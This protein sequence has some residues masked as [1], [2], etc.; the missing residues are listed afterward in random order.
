[1][2][3]CALLAA[4]LLSGC[5]D[6]ELPPDE[7]D[8]GEQRV[9]IALPSD[10]RDFLDWKSFDVTGT[11]HASA[12]GPLVAYVNQL[13]DPGSSEFPIGTVIVKAVEA[14]KHSEWTVHAM[15]KRGGDFNPSGAYDWEFFELGFSSKDVP[16]INWRGEKPPNGEGYQVKQG[17]MTVEADCNGC[18]VSSEND[19]VLSPELALDAL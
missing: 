11:M 12:K 9:F 19:A 17:N 2:A 16:I 8:A 15:A 4:S 5:L 14:G 1:M 13:P 6:N 7:S 3:A 18:H 10:F